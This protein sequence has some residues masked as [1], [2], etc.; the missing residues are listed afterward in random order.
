MEL[1]GSVLGLGA[2]SSVL[3]LRSKR[4]GD[5]ERDGRAIRLGMTECEKEVCVQPKRVW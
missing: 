2:E 3:Q 4:W 1:L 5:G